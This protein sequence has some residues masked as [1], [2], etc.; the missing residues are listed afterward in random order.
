MLITSIGW[1]A[2]VANKWLGEAKDLAT[3]GG[4]GQG[5]RI[6]YQGGSEDG[7]TRDV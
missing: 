4:I 2:V 3:I 7:F 6:A 5:L 1:H